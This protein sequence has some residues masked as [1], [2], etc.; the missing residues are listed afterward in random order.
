MAITYTTVSNPR[1]SNSA[2]TLIDLDVNFDHL[3]ED[4]VPF[5]ASADDVEPHGV[6][7]Y[8]RA[9][10]GDFGPIAAYSPPA[11]LTGDDAMQELRW[12]RN[13]ILKE[14]DVN[15][16]PDKW[17]AMTSEQQTAWSNY[18]Q[19][20]RDLP[21]NS[22]DAIAAWVEAD[23]NHTNWSNVNWPTAPGA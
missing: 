22:P 1:W 19:A 11:D 16:L 18:R 12:Q 20:L 6:E 13:R 4:S 3:P 8:N 14:S 9:I 21:A 17:A 5:M 2:Q 15:V 10:A 7:L 23:L